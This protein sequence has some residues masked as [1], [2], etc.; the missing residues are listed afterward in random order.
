MKR[1]TYCTWTCVA[2]LIS[3]RLPLT[4]SPL[5]FQWRLEQYLHKAPLGALVQSNAQSLD[6]A[7]QRI[8]IQRGHR[9]SLPTTLFFFSVVTVVLF[10]QRLF[11]QRGH[12][13]SVPTTPFL[14]SVI[15]VVLFPR[16]LF[17]FSVVTIVFFGRLFYSV[18]SPSFFSHDAFLIQRGHHRSL[19]TTHFYSAWSP[20]FSSHM[21]RERWWP[22]GI[23]KSVV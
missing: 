19:P 3:R 11:I 10:P 21:G 2:P 20:S 1:P 22:R 14:F 23:K 4:K 17:L 18:W 16:R 7:I 6:T 12:H 13:R 15:T 9:R 5:T 8:F